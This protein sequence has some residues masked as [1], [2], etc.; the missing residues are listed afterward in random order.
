MLD[1]DISEDDDFVDQLPSEM[2]E[3]SRS[4]TPATGSDDYIPATPIGSQM[5]VRFSTRSGRTIAS[6]VRTTEITTVPR[7][8]TP[9]NKGSGPPANVNISPEL[10]QVIAEN[11]RNALEKRKR[12]LEMGSK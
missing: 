7:P 1:N 9:E 11:R 3:K 10:Q 2:S 12:K 4:V 5:E 8:V 6:V